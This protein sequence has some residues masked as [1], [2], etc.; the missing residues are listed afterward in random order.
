MSNGG[1]GNAARKKDWFCKLQSCKGQDGKHFINFG[2]RTSCKR[3]GLDKGTVHWKDVDFPPMRGNQTGIAERQIRQA[4][5]AAKESKRIKELERQLRDSKAK[6]KEAEAAARP[7]VAMVHPSQEEGVESPELDLE[8]MQKSVATL[9][10]C[11]LTADSP[12][13]TQLEERIA[14]ER[15]KR[16]ESQ[17]LSTQVRAIER[18][19]AKK[20]KA[21]EAAIAQAAEAK[22]AVEE[23]QCAMGV[24][25][26]R[27]TELQDELQKLEKEQ[28]ELCKTQATVPENVATAGAGVQDIEAVRS[29]LDKVKGNKDA[30]QAVSEL[31]ARLQMRQ[32]ELGSAAAMSDGEMDL[33]AEDCVEIDEMVASLVPPPGDSGGES[34]EARERVAKQRE[35][36]KRKL[37]QQ[38]TNLVRRKVKQKRPTG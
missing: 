34:G 25:E 6:L 13:V 10:A 24:A 16:A 35:D 17:P 5:D 3:C 12:E 32:S 31:L 11:G 23:A 18:R 19:V 9:K 1:N 37:M 14:A 30:E 29:V 7:P 33:D 22:C 2:W 38:S 20:R 15:K 4:T 21:V 26:R 36:I 27:T 8:G 28:A